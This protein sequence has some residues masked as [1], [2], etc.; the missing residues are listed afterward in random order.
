MKTEEITKVN[1]T[2][3][4]RRAYARCWIPIDP[5]LLQE[6]LSVVRVFIRK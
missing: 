5:M 1:V 4:L 3:L 2:L 6:M